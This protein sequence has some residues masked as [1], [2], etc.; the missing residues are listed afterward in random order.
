M[1]VQSQPTAVG[2]PHTHH[3]HRTDGFRFG[4]K[5]VELRHDGLFVR[6]RHVEADQLGVRTHPVAKVIHF[7][8]VK[9]L[10]ARIDVLASELF[11]K[12]GRGKTVTEG[13][14]DESVLLHEA[15]TGLFFCSVEGGESKSEAPEFNLA[16]S[17]F[18]DHR[19]HHFALGKGLHRGG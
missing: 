14:S 2:P 12:K 5:G 11:C 16:E 18:F 6:N 15:K 17:C 3:I 9:I 10:I 13:V 8:E 7:G 4:R 1:P 19:F